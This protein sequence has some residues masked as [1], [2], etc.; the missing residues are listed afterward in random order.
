MPWIFR[1]GVFRIWCW[2]F[3]LFWFSVFKLF[4]R[5]SCW[6]ARIE[7]LPPWLRLKYVSPFLILFMLIDIGVFDFSSVV[8]KLFWFCWFVL[9]GIPK[10]LF[11]LWYSCFMLCI[12]GRLNYCRDSYWLS[13]ITPFGKCKFWAS[14]P[15][16][17][18]VIKLLDF[19]TIWFLCW[20]QLLILSM[21][22]W[23]WYW[24]YPRLRPP[25]VSLGCLMCMS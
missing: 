4:W 17:F 21:F 5:R 6:E 11:S 13:A 22:S 7:W 16:L 14:P 18:M 19:L 10:M 2:L 8:Y 25:D 12:K 9:L 1:C 15:Y 24:L 23:L 3:I 20:L